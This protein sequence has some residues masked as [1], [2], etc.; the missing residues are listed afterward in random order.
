MK[1][2]ATAGEFRMRREKPDKRLETR[3]DGSGAG[4]GN[5]N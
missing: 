1:L 5:L 4:E 2:N 3:S